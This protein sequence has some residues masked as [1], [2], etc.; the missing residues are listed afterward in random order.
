M[1]WLMAVAVWLHACPDSSESYQACL[2]LS[3]PLTLYAPSIRTALIESGSLPPGFDGNLLADSPGSVWSEALNDLSGCVVGHLVLQPGFPVTSLSV[4]T[5]QQRHARLFWKCSRW[6]DSFHS[7]LDVARCLR[8][9]NPEKAHSLVAGGVRSG[10]FWKASR[11]SV[12]RFLEARCRETGR[13]MRESIPAVGAHNIV[14]SLPLA[15]CILL[16]S[17]RWQSYVVP[18]PKTAQGSLVPIRGSDINFRVYYPSNFFVC[19][20]LRTV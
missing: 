7:T 1:I 4:L 19:C 3:G 14:L 5:E 2:S 15:H 18:V 16:L 13:E 8:L 12:I 6:S 17:G 9:Q 11:W 10:L 20:S